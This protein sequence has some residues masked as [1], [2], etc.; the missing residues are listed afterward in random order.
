MKD[1]TQTAPSINL[2]L[3]GTTV[4][5]EKSSVILEDLTKGTQGVY[6]LGDIIQGFTIATILTDSV[7]LTK[8]DQEAGAHASYGW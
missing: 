8:Q 1:K 5:G 2:R 6:R 7:T 3:V 4:F